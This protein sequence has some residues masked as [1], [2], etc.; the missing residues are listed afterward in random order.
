MHAALLYLLAIILSQTPVPVTPDGWDT[1]GYKAL[2]AGSAEEAA[3]DFAQALRL[4]PSDVVALAGSGAAANLLGHPA[5]ARLALTRALRED[6]ALTPASLLLGELLYRDNDLQGAIDVY[7]QAL[8]RAPG[9]PRLTA[10]LDQWKREAALQDGFSSR[11]ATHFTVLF[12]GPPDQP[13]ASHVIDLLEGIY[14]QVGGALGA[15]PTNA[16][17][18]VL[19]SREQFRDVTQSPAWAGGLFDGRIRVPI[20]GRV[21]ERELRRVL[22]HEFTHAV[23]RSV[24]P[25]GVP[26]WLNEGLA[27][28]MER[29][30][31]SAPPLPAGPLPTLHA[32][33]GSFDALS[34]EDA[35]AA[36]A[37]CAAATQALL[38]R[39]GPMTIPNLLTNLGSGLPFADAFERAAQVSY[40][41][42][43]Q[44]WR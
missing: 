20:G 23:V 27:V 14:W 36:Y 2:R 7:S 11:M 13:L 19:Y 25:R 39:G 29:G 5:E 10:R 30:D 21:D 43:Q 40:A 12:E 3:A 8:A 4:N 18:V 33:E 31:G 42:F 32:L 9:D 26:Q 6:P 37:T 1:A 17:T 15:Y 41:Q 44:T 16:V 24:A 35:R 28:L 38:D 22:A 34:G